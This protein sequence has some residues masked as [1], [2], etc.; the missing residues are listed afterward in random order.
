MPHAAGSAQPPVPA[1]HWE[2]VH[3]TMGL[4]TPGGGVGGVGGKWISALKTGL[5]LSAEFCKAWGREGRTVFD[6]FC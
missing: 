4:Q 2:N 5:H 3:G 1:G 6:F